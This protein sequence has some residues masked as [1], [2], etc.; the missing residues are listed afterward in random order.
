MGRLPG[1]EPGDEGSTP[2][3]RTLNRDVVAGS[4][5]P[6]TESDRGSPSGAETS[7]LPK[8]AGRETSPQQVSKKAPIPGQSLLVV[9]PGSEPGGRWFD[10]NP[11]SF[12]PVGNWPTTLP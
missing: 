6:D 3:P 11:R 12:G 2:S 4:H 1:F 8:W 7:G 9:T 5:D 10:S